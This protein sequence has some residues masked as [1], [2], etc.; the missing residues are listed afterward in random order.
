MTELDKLKSYIKNLKAKGAKETTINVDY[1]DK[2]LNE[3]SE[4]GSAP[5]PRVETKIDA[6]GG[7]F[8]GE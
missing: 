3:L 1:L 7:G 4:P 6:D 8:S 2:I 5:K